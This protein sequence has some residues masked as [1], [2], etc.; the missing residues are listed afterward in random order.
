MD[1]IT[2]SSNSYSL[3]QHINKKNET[4]IAITADIF[5]ELKKRKIEN[6]TH[7]RDVANELE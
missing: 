3:H 2:N 1:I 5:T 4:E 6:A 7:L